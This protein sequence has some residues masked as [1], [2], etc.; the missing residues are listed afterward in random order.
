VGG[1]RDGGAGWGGSYIDKYW[2]P[3][4]QVK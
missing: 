3:T 2:N 1:G 4:S